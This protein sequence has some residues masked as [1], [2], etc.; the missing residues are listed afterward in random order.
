MKADKVRKP[1]FYWVRFGGAVIV[2]EYAILQPLRCC[3]REC[4]SLDQR[5]G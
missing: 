3:M 5:S 2:A 4:Y 1:G